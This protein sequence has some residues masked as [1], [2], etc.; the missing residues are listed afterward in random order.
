[1]LKN[2]IRP[3]L[4][5]ENEN[6]PQLVNNLRDFDA[7]YGLEG[8]TLVASTTVNS[9][10]AS[11]FDRRWFYFRSH[12]S[13]GFLVGGPITP[14]VGA[15]PLVSNAAFATTAVLGFRNVYLFGMDCGRRKGANHHAKDAVYYE[16]DYDNYLEGESLEL[17]ENEFNR[18]VPGNF[19]GTVLTAWHLDMSRVNISG[20]QRLCRVNLINCSDGAEIAGAQPKAAAAVKINFPPGKQGEVLGRV[21]E[22]LKSFEAGTFI[23]GEPLG[24]YARA[25]DDFQDR[26]GALMDAGMKEDKGFWDLEQRVLGFQHENRAEFLG[27]LAIIGGTYNSMIRLGA[28]GGTR[29]KDEKKRLAFLRFFIGE[30]RDAIL[31]MTGRI[32]TMLGEMAAGQEVLSEAEKAD[33]C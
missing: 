8:I 14:L 24:A 13:P 29:I 33:A 3:D 30:Y 21:A 12:L 2:G 26:F 7:E 32:G 25:A 10:I 28:F 16:D 15:G 27:V 6:T 22:Q 4:H 19:G 31:W 20:M 18:E 1:M 11:L 17:I 23:E 5:V 9:Q